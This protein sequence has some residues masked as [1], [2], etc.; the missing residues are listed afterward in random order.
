MRG[1]SQTT[2]WGVVLDAPDAL[3]LADF[4]SRLLDWP[5]AK[6]EPG[7]AVI[8]QPDSTT[9]LSFQTEPAYVRPVWP[10]TDGNQQMMMHLDIEVDDLPAAVADAIDLGASLP[11]HQP[12]DNVRV[13]LDPAGHPFCLY[14]DLN[15]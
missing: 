3:V 13:L 5:I 9:Y 6:T 15:E 11:A 14:L 10:A 12:Q 2:W 8:G 7:W 1:R 4:Y